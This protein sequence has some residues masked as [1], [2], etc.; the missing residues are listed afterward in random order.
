MILQQNQK[1]AIWGWA[2]PGEEVVV[3]SSWEATL[4]Q[5]RTVRVAGKFF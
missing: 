3:A 4:Q 2:E 1:N 5:S